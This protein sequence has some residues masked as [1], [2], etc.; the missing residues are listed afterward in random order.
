MAIF[1]M[2]L[3]FSVRVEKIEKFYF[4]YVKFEFFTVTTLLL[5]SD[6]FKQEFSIF[7]HII[8]C[9]VHIIPTSLYN[10]KYAILVTFGFLLII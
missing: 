7:S 3:A 10:Q 2:Y 5:I 1:L 4:K 8:L 6:F 9:F